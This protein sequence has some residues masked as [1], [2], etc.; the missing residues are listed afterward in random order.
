MSCFID[1]LSIVYYYGYIEKWCLYIR[2]PSSYNT[3]RKKGKFPIN[4]TWTHL[5]F[6]NYCIETAENNSFKISSELYRT[7][8][9]SSVDS[10]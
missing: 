1:F 3:E 6:Y 7:T 10:Q 5:I 8:I 9:T 2:L 4:A